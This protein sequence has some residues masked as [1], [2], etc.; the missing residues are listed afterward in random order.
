MNE[1]KLDKIHKKVL[2]LQKRIKKKFN[3]NTDKIKDFVY[4]LNFEN[5]IEFWNEWDNFYSKKGLYSEY[6]DLKKEIDELKEENIYRG[7]NEK[8][9]D[10]LVNFEEELHS[11]KSNIEEYIQLLKE[12]AAEKMIER[13]NDAIKKQEKHDKN[14]MN[15]MGIFLSIFSVIGL[16]VSGVLNLESNHTAIW[17]MMCGTI[18]ITMTGLFSLINNKFETMKI[19]IIIGG[20]VLFCAGGCIRWKF[21]DDNEKLIKKEKFEQVEEEIQN[22]ENEVLDRNSDYR[23]QIKDLKEEIRELQSI[24]KKLEKNSQN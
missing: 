6:L 3:K 8:W 2:D 22:I 4:K 23:N 19:L 10:I 7:T 9:N 16:G 17:L 1:K 21:P 12:E 15:M 13:I 14:I 18:L 5:D 11:C 24:M 20:L